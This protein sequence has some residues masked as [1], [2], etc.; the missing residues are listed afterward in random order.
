MC[1]R[2][3]YLISKLKL[4]VC[5]VLL[6]N[7]DSGINPRP[8]ASIHYNDL[9]EI[10]NLNNTKVPI[11]YGSQ[12]G[13]ARKFAVDL[14]HHLHLCG[15][16]N[17]VIDLKQLSMDVLVNLSFLDKC[18]VVFVLATYGEGEP[19]D[20]SRKFMEILENSHERLNN[21]HFSV[22]A[23]GNSMYTYFNAFG[24]SVDRLLVKHGAKRFQAISLGDELN[25]LESAFVAWRDQL[26][27]SMI[28]FFDMDNG[29]DCLNKQYERIYFLKR[30]TW[31]LP[32]IPYYIKLFISRTYVQQTLPYGT[33]HYVHVPVVVNE[34]LYCGSSR[35]CRHIELDLS[36]TELSYKTGDHVAL[37]APNPP[38]IVKRIGD[39]LNVDLNTVIN[40]EAVD[41]H[42]LIRHPFPCPCTYRH[43]FTYFVDITGPPGKNLFSACLNSII[44]PDELQFVRLLIS[45]SEE[46]KKLYSKWILEDHR[47]LTE[48]LQDLK[49]FRPPADLL[50]ELLNPLKPRLY[51]ISSSSLVHS[52]R[53]HITAAVVKYQTTSGR[54]FKGLATSWLYSLHVENCQQTYIKIPITIHSS[55]FYL[56]R[57][58]TIPIIM[59]AAGT[60]LAPF[61]AF[62]QERIK[63]ANDKGGRNGQMM[64]FFGCRHETED[65][66]YST[67]LKQ[68]CATGLLEIFSAF[69]RDSNDGTKVY[70][71]H[72]LLQMGHKVWKL[73]DESHAY[74]YV[75]GN[76]SGMA[77]DV[78]SC[79]IEIIAKHSQLT[80][81]AAT[82]YV[83][84][85]RKQG[86]YRTDVWK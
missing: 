54:L 25:E 20:N 50:L 14:G 53:I 78:H 61:R 40:L 1:Q 8:N 16:R 10:L 64:L 71:Q 57:S 52:R 42:S 62:I 34:E 63:M 24:I 2:G 11:F 5:K 23:L 58:R 55:K 26:T 70:V 12:T 38:D 30:T 86:R 6:T 83:M 80:N 74:F 77:R 67:E 84:D 72:K 56:P 51:S 60:G 81:A 43:A 75:C 32:L 59:V 44:D 85:L 69:S 48:V 29:Q 19:T 73:L 66:I 31:N 13:T 35:S 41:S 18:V 49:T 21:L 22:F 7:N 36:G 46:G 39:L 17:L 65:F 37:L 76:A 68:A 3:V 79:L 82:N 27:S 9:L 4:I 47:G 28:N 15:I 45:N 33:E